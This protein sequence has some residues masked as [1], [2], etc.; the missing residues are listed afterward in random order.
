[1]LRVV[2]V[3]SLF[4]LSFALTEL[5]EYSFRGPFQSGNHEGIRVVDG[6]SLGGSGEVRRHFVRLTPDRQS[7][8]GQLWNHNALKLNTL[9]LT[10][11]FRISGQGKKYFGDGLTLWGEYRCLLVRCK[12]RTIGYVLD[13]CSDDV[14]VL[15]RGSR[16]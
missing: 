9:S 15:A 10:L 5:S 11:R 13:H 3:A 7:K 16:R 14:A 6:W 1:M 12:D 2:A 4:A 8:K